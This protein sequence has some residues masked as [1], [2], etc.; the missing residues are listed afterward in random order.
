MWLT[1]C[2]LALF[3]TQGWFISRPPFKRIIVGVVATAEAALTTHSDLGCLG[4]MSKAAAPRLPLL[5]SQGGWSTE[6][7]ETCRT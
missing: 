3:Q 1:T 7:E 6:Q 2:P 5:Q 4:F